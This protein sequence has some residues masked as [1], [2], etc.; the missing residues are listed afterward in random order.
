M[1]R[2][3]KALRGTAR[4][5]KPE[6][7]IH[8]RA[9]AEVRACYATLGRRCFLFH[10]ANESMVPVQYRTELKALGVTSGVP[11]IVI[12][13]PGPLAFVPS[14][15]LALEVKAP[16]GTLSDDQR[17]WLEAYA[18]TGHNA[19]VTYGHEQTAICLVDHGYISS[20]ACGRWIAWA[21]EYDP[22]AL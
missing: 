15:G 10:A 17:E 13:G 9:V 22:I 7:R 2:A 16:K 18:A 12:V 11:D 6:R 14:P 4:R 19:R 5:D 1:T 20:E 3:R 8:V 21:R